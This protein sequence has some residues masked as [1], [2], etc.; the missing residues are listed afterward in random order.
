[1]TCISIHF[2]LICFS[3]LILSPS[4]CHHAVM[5]AKAHTNTPPV[6]HSIKTHL[7]TVP[8]MPLACQLKDICQSCQRFR[9]GVLLLSVAL[10]RYADPLPKSPSTYT[11]WGQFNQHVVGPIIYHTACHYNN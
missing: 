5:V 7:Y 10:L 2:L 3:R 4:H 11:I 9:D 6:C 8:G 1:M